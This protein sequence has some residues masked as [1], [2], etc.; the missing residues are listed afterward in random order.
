MSMERNMG[1]LELELSLHS[2]F[3]YYC[4]LD[5]EFRILKNL[6]Q[7]KWELS[8]NKQMRLLLNNVCE[9]IMK[10]LINSLS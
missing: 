1:K 3:R 4:R 8:K 9:I 7:G 6:E 10:D 2:Y 5:V